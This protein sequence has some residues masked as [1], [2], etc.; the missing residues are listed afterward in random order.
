MPRRGWRGTGCRILG[1]SPTDGSARSRMQCSVVRLVHIDTLV[2]CMHSLQ[3]HCFARSVIRV[4]SFYQYSSSCSSS[5][6]PTPFIPCFHSGLEAGNPSY[7]YTPI[8]PTLTTR[9]VI[10]LPQKR[11][12]TLP[13]LPILLLL[14]GTGFLLH[15]LFFP[16]PPPHPPGKYT[17]S[18]FLVKPSD[19]LAPP[20]PDRPSY[21]PEPLQPKKK[22]ML[23]PDA[24][25]YVYG[26]K[27]VPEGKTGEELPYYAYLAMR[28][29]LINL[30]PK[31][32]Y[33]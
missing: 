26:L 4:L 10:P 15:S 1:P 27:P 32:I 31:A 14:L 33:L 2:P 8:L 6:T 16:P 24:V 29:A 5:L 18:P 22:G 21:I 7:V 17:S 30:K 12:I 19:F 13:A 23:V 20:P 11:H 9:Q 28:S 25:H 3:S